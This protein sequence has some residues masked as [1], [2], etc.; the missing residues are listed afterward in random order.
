MELRGNSIIV[1]VEGWTITPKNLKKIIIKN[2]KCTEPNRMKS[3]YL[4]YGDNSHFQTEIRC[5]LLDLCILQWNFNYIT[6]TYIFSWWFWI[7]DNLY[8]LNF[9]IFYLKLVHREFSS[10]SVQNFKTLKIIGLNKSDI[11][12]HCVHL[13]DIYY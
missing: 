8:L 3:A 6:T 5:V 1:L 10:L 7:R 12:K 13:K 9:K 4:L 2:Q 11:I